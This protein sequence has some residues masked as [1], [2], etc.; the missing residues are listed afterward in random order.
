[1]S[2]AIGVISADQVIE[3]FIS[4]WE[5]FMDDELMITTVFVEDFSLLR[6]V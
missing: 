3:R 2:Q 4:R 1:M 5:V 6:A